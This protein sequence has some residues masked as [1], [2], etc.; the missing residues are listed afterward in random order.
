MLGLRHDQGNLAS[1]DAANV[2]EGVTDSMK[3]R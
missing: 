3:V 1:A 2:K